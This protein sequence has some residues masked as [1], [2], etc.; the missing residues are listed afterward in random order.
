MPLPLGT[1][2]TKRGTGPLSFDDF[3]SSMGS[4]SHPRVDYPIDVDALV[5]KMLTAIKRGALPDSIVIQGIS[6]SHL[7]VRMKRPERTYR[8]K[9][10]SQAE[11]E[12]NLKALRWFDKHLPGGGLE[13]VTFT[14][15]SKTAKGF[16]P[17]RGS[18]MLY[19]DNPAGQHTSVSFEFYLPHQHIHYAANTRDL[20]PQGRPRWRCMACRHPMPLREQRARGLA[21]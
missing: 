16:T 1:A 14:G 17:D 3:A 10:F 6:T 18:Y 9:F 11:G 8:H 15:V 21:L 19:G 7:T 20:D 5:R 13:R 12:D 2:P 4:Y